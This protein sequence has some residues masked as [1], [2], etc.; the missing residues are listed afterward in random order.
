MRRPLVLVGFSYLLTLAAAVYLGAKLSFVLF[1]CCLALFAVT[2]FLKKTR[3]VLVFPVAF[4]T[5]AVAFGAFAGYSHAAVEPPRMLDGLDATVNGTICELPYS[6]YGRWYYIVSIDS[7]SVPGAPQSFKI[8][9]SSQQKLASEPYSRIHGKVHFFRPQGGNGYSAESYYESRGIRLFAYLYEYDE[10]VRVESPKSKPIYY[11]ALILR[12]KMISSVKS[13]LPEKEAGLIQGMLLGDKTTL[14]SETITDFRAAGASHLLAVSGLHMATV[15]QLLLLLFGLFQIPRKFSAALAGGGILCFM[16]VTGFLPSVMRSGIMFLLCL[17]APIVSRR[18]DSLNSLGTAILIL[19]LPNPYAAAD[20]GLLLSCSATL[21]L[22]LLARPVQNWLNARLGHVRLLRPL[23]RGIN[24]ILSTTFAA[25]LFTLP[26]VILSFGSISLIAPLSNLLMLVPASLMIGFSAVGAV[27]GIFAP[28]SFLLMP[29]ALISG[30][31]AKYLLACAHLLSQIPYASVS[32]SYGYVYLWLAGSI[33]LFAVAFVCRSRRKLMITSAVLCLVML[34][35]GILSYGIFSR[36]VTR[37]AVLDVG[38]G[39]SVAVTKDGAAAVFGC[40]GYQS[41]KIASYLSGKNIRHI[42]HLNLLTSNREEAV[43]AADLAEMFSPGTLCAPSDFRYDGFVQKAA[44]CS[45]DVFWQENPSNTMIWQDVKIQLY[46]CGG[47]KAV[48][49]IAQNIS[50]LIVPDGA[51]VSMIPPEWYH[52]DFLITDLPPEKIMLLHPLCTVLSMDY[53]DLTK[54]QQPK[55]SHILWTGGFGT[56]ELQL[57][58]DRI[59]SVGR[60]S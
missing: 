26:I 21:G 43:N 33:L 3:T 25:I 18:A 51:D 31:L 60:E 6:Q 32:A 17:A 28:Q 56:I 1:W 48:Q 57:K 13:M 30:S 7:V 23:V 29:F 11:Y 10:P 8:R 44:A 12:Q 39:L 41:A 45:A 53:R 38:T 34:C 40:D 24:G 54:I 4:L 42:D 52:P 9:L 27:I 46:D 58:G 14:T 55:E 59:L 47:S 36:G 49:M 5:A 2:A 22:I 15:A 50:I 37:I 20:V 16:A 19:C 35:T